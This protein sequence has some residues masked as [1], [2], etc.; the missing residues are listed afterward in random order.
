[1]ADWNTKAKML[2]KIGVTTVILLGCF[3]L[4]FLKYPEDHIKWAFGLIGVVVGYWLK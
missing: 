3:T 4:I 2:T 1:M